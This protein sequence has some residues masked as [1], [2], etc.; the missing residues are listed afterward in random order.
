MRGIGCSLCRSILS[1][2]KRDGFEN[3]L[4][5]GKRNTWFSQKNDELFTDGGV[6]C[7]FKKTQAINVR[8]KFTECQTHAKTLWNARAHQPVV[9]G[10]LDET[11]LPVYV[12]PFY[13]YFE[14]TETRTS[15]L[16]ATRR[17]RQLNIR[18]NRSLIGQQ[19]ALSSTNTPTLNTTV[20]ETGRARGSGE[21]AANV[22]INEATLP[23]A[24]PSSTPPMS[25]VASRTTPQRRVAPN[26]GRNN[27]NTRTRH[28][29]DSSNHLPH[30]PPSTSG[31]GSVNMS[32]MEDGYQVIAHSINNLAYQNRIRRVADI[33]NDLRIN[34]EKRADLRN[35]GADEE[36]LDV[37]T[38]I[39]A[40][41]R[42][43]RE[44]ANLY[45]EYFSNQFRNVVN[46]DI[47]N[48]GTSVSSDNHISDS[49]T[50]T[51]ND[52]DN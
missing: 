15:S 18:V 7:R 35:N 6:L 47:M 11:D 30:L 52:T 21:I 37:Y 10:S 5:H 19:A 23:S 22:T 25:R 3:S 12:L 45:D 1:L 28:Y 39:I 43:E 29:N 40:D 41:L 14:F 33:N 32:R 38:T 26:D 4:A 24:G 46:H 9:D 27:R 2:A 16:A 42:V 20:A 51:Q 49:L 31:M 36:L 48:T 17:N 34:V 44:R 8:R 50:D 13:E